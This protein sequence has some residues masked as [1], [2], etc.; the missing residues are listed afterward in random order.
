[1]SM[2][3]WTAEEFRPSKVYYRIASCSDQ[4]R[5]W[6]GLALV[7]L[8]MCSGCILAATGSIASPWHLIIFFVKVY[9]SITPET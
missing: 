5:G 3:L 4:L 2:L 7:L 6:G 9:L 8:L 1:M